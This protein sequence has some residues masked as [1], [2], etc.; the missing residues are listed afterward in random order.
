MTD[1]PNE[2]G[3]AEA[4]EE[5]DGCEEHATTG[6]H[7]DTCHWMPTRATT[8]TSEAEGPTLLQSEYPLLAE[9]LR[10]AARAP[11]SDEDYDQG[12]EEAVLSVLDGL[13]EVRAWRENLKRVLRDWLRRRP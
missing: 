6:R 12:W 10:R 4:M 9:D 1:S 11:M 7:A 2:P 8:V 5:C 13:W 3:G